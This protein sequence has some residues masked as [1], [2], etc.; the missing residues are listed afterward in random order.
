MERRILNAVE[1]DI[2]FLHPFTVISETVA[3]FPLGYLPESVVR[4]AETYAAE[5]FLHYG[6]VTA[7]AYRVGI[8]SLALACQQSDIFLPVRVFAA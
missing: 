1:H 8:A 3:C 6:F 7:P 5:T 2:T 4:Q